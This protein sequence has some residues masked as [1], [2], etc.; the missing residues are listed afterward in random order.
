MFPSGRARNIHF[1]FYINTDTASSIAEE[2]VEQLELCEEDVVCIAALIDSLIGKLVPCWK[3][4]IQGNANLPITLYKGSPTLPNSMCSWG[5]GSAKPL[6]EAVS[7]QDIYSKLALMKYQDSQGSANSAA[8][9]E[10]NISITSE[11]SNL[12]RHDD[13]IRDGIDNQE[14]VPMNVCTQNSASSSFIMYSC[15]GL[16]AS[17]SCLS[18]L[19]LTD[20]DQPEC[21]DLKEELDAID[22]QYQSCIEEILKMREAALEHA[23][24][25]WIS[26]KK[27]SVP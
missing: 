3:P 6:V 27:I 7:A 18:S 21:D 8:S 23:K 5:S 14:S 11:G 25:K 10:Y 12:A 13:K 15:S 20:K 16:E 17:L 2:M 9:T 24:R 19:S 4:S 22:S 1:A 26:K